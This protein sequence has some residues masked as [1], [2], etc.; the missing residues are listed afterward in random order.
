MADKFGLSRPGG[1]VGR[2]TESDLFIIG[3]IKTT[4]AATDLTVGTYGAGSNLQLSVDA[5]GTGGIFGSVGSGGIHLTTLGVLEVDSDDTSYVWMNANS[6]DDKSLRIHAQNSG[7]G[8]GILYLFGNDSAQIGTSGSQD[9]VTV[10]FVKGISMRSPTAVHIGQDPDDVGFTYGPIYIGTLGDTHN[11]SIGNLNGATPVTVHAG[12]DGLGLKSSE[13]IT[14][15]GRGCLSPLTYNQVGDLDLVPGFVATSIVGAFNELK[16]SI[17]TNVTVTVT[18]VGTTTV[19]EFTVNSDGGAEWFYVL[20]SASGDNLRSGKIGCVWDHSASSV[21][22]WEFGTSDIGDTSDITLQV[23]HT[24]TTIQLQLINATGGEW[25]FTA[26]RSIAG[27]GVVGSVVP[28]GWLEITSILTGSGVVDTFNPQSDGMVVWN[29]V[30]T[31][32]AGNTTE[33]TVTAAWSVFVGDV[34]YSIQ[35]SPDIGDTS[36][37]DLSVSFAGGVLSLDATISFGTWTVAGTKYTRSV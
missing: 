25:T 9:N 27:A 34:T 3:G 10:D 13:D 20:T 2:A 26:T 5:A 28:S 16:S 33:R 23:V 32:T 31:D 1:N 30:V 21:E 24:G 12:T 4:S 35:S 11:I 8:R 36:P 17:T 29:L 22:F 6:G 19:D 18:T 7:A 14:F 15:D 37:I